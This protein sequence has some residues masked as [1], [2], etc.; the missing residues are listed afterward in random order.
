[1]MRLGGQRVCKADQQPQALT[2]HCLLFFLGDQDPCCTDA[3]TKQSNP[4][5]NQHACVLARTLACTSIGLSEHTRQYKTPCSAHIC[6]RLVWRSS[7]TGLLVRHWATST[8]RGPETQEARP[9]GQQ[10]GPE[11]GL[12]VRHWATSTCRPWDPGGTGQR[13]AGAEKTTL[14]PAGPCGGHG[15]IHAALHAVAVTTVRP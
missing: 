6:N 13:A 5:R 2:Q 9:R 8:C 15:G 1:M 4:T 10:Q 12:L 11:G 7:S 14:L 3:Y